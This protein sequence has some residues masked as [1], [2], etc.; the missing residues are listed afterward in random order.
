MLAL[1]AATTLAVFGPESPQE[2]QRRAV[3]EF[4]KVLEA[5]GLAQTDFFGDEATQKL[6]SLRWNETQLLEWLERLNV[7]RLTVRDAGL[8]VSRGV[9]GPNTSAHVEV[10]FKWLGEVGTARSLPLLYRIDRMEWVTSRILERQM[11]AAMARSDCAPPSESEVQAAE[12]SLHDFVVIR[13]DA[14]AFRFERLT[15]DELQDLAYFMAAVSEAGPPVRQSGGEDGW[16]D[17]LTGAEE[18]DA[19]A[20]GSDEPFTQAESEELSLSDDYSHDDSAEAAL[21][22]GDLDRFIDLAR[23]YLQ[24]FGY[25]SSLDGPRTNRVCH[26]RHLNSYVTQDLAEVLEARGEFHEAAFLYRVA[27]P[28]GPCGSSVGSIWERRI[29]GFIRSHEK[30]GRCRAV[31]AERLLDFERSVEILPG[32][33]EHY[34]YGPSRLTAVGFDV[35]KLYRGALLTAFREGGQKELKARFSK[36]PAPLSQ[37]ALDRL[38]RKGTEAW[39]RRIRALEGLADGTGREAMR[40]LIPLALA[41]VPSSESGLPTLRVRAI[42]ALGDLLHRPAVDPCTPNDEWGSRGS[43]GF[44]GHWRK[45]VQ[46]LTECGAVLNADERDAL[47]GQLF[48]LLRSSHADV[49][50]E[51]AETLGKI[52]SPSA[53]AELKHLVA[54]PAAGLVLNEW[55]EEDLRWWAVEIRRAAQNAIETIDAFPERR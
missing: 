49:R 14:S 17:D 51:G 47:S 32:P 52:G 43:F 6:K 50:R 8:W 16:S 7:Q 9:D 30:A 20:N 13:A 3:A 44:G 48:P 15:A 27:I 5:L 34:T 29:R 42:E 18:T 39:E 35:A 33:N 25:P 46:S 36:A 37:L 19:D 21:R 55:D 22:R 23:A 31:V 12:A 38:A 11:E 40:R 24:F 54:K 28:H 41:N 26:L 1:L 53:L 10:L 2:A 45:K 4:S